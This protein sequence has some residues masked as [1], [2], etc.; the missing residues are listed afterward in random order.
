[1]TVT[2]EGLLEAIAKAIYAASPGGKSWN[3]AVNMAE[4]APTFSGG[5]NHDIARMR[6]NQCR[7]QARAALTAI[8]AA[9]YIVV[10]KP[11]ERPDWL[12]KL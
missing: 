12:P 1:M 11:V 5:V 4:A 10:P 9:G 8:E 2:R 6:V 7:D 3:E